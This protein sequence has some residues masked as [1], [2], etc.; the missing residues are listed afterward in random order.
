M[1]SGIHCRNIFTAQRLALYM[2]LN[3]ISINFHLVIFISLETEMKIV[4]PK[5]DPCGYPSYYRRI[6]PV[7]NKSDK[8]QSGQVHYHILLHSCRD[9]K[10]QI[11]SGRLLGRFARKQ[12][13]NAIVCTATNANLAFV[14]GEDIQAYLGPHRRHCEC[15]TIP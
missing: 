5:T 13:P 4:V 3:R 11:A 9:L 6:F 15:Q 1:T 10:A 7:S 8:R 14:F 2:N 12:T